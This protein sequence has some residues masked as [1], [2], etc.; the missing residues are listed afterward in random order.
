[1]PEPTRK[2]GGG[3]KPYRTF[4]TAITFRITPEL[5]SGMKALAT[6]Y[7]VRIEDVYRNAVLMLLKL[8]QRKACIYQGAPRTTDSRHV[9]IKME[10]RLKALVREAAHGDHH[11]VPDFFETAASLYLGKHGDTWRKQNP[12][13]KL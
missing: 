12:P 9:N 6:E 10:D 7:R 11:A 8:R 3:P 4:H 13:L 2:R 5:H 1:M